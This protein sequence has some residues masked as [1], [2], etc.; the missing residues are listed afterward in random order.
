[1]FEALSFGT[2]TTSY[3]RRRASCCA[4]LED[5]HPPRHGAGREHGI[6]AVIDLDFIE[7]KA[8]ADPASGCAPTGGQV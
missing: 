4:T 2:N 7:A 1:M 5:F 8:V 6:H 3:I